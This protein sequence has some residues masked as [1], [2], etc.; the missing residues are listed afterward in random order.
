LCL[1]Q[2]DSKS[3]LQIKKNLKK[4]VGIGVERVQTPP[5]PPPQKGKFSKRKKLFMWLPLFSL[6]YD[7]NTV[8]MQQ[9]HHA[10]TP[11]IK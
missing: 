7:Q 11:R 10:V 8:N 3:V 4:G 2:F 6:L 5:P 1:Q 9:M